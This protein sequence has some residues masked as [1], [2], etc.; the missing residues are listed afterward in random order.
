MTTDP[1]ADM[2]IRLKNGS[3][4]GQ[5]MVA[6]PFSRLKLAVVETLVRAGYLKSVGKK[7][8]KVKKYLEAELIYH[9]H[10]PK[11]TEVI[12]VSKPSRRIYHRVKDIRS[13][14]QGFGLAVYSTPKGILTD[15]E[16][17]AAKVGG[18]ILCKLW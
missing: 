17:K 13:V 9:N 1:I 8:K 15:R 12:K 10:E 3:R 16:A 2:L 5:P 4:A 6:F 11:L 7:G 14:R 18:E